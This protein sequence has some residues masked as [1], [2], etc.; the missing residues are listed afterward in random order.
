M[1]SHFG[2]LTISAQLFISFT[3]TA[4]HIRVSVPSVDS[5]RTMST[6]PMG[7]LGKVIVFVVKGRHTH[8]PCIYVS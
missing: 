4:Y 2:T 3:F 6:V 1:G 5:C 8:L 7:N